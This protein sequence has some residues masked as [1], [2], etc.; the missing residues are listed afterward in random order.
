MS[1]LKKREKKASRYK[2]KVDHIK[3]I[4]RARI[5][6]GLPDMSTSEI[7]NDRVGNFRIGG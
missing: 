6:S 5:V 1:I 3:R 4:V 2:V 7:G